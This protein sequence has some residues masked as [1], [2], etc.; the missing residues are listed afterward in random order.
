MVVIIGT[1]LTLSE[2]GPQEMERG[3]TSFGGVL[4]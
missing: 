1:L 3:V 2:K 4:G